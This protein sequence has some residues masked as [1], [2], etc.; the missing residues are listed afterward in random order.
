[1]HLEFTPQKFFLVINN[2]FKSNPNLSE[3]YSEKT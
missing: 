2:E 3:K 1:M